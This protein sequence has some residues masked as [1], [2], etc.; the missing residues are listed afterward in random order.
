MADSPDVIHSSAISRLGIRYQKFL[1]DLVPFR[2]ARWSFVIALL[3]VYGVRV[4]F[5]QGWYIV[6]YA[7]AIYLLNIFIAFLT[8]KFD[9]AL[10]DE[11]TSE[12][13]PKLPISS[14]EDFKPF[15]RRLPEFKFWVRAVYSTI[16]AFVCT[17]FAVCNVPVFWPIL[18]LYFI[19]LFT[20]TMK[21]QIAHMI[22]YRYL[23]FTHG[24]RRYRGREDNTVIQ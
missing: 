7:L 9:P 1:D 10:D 2:V 18:V 24:K 16:V 8:P 15:I 14:K 20:L 23:P 21:R 19:V 22:K 13:G 17:F 3:V 4:F 6:S 5:L 12:D 11:A